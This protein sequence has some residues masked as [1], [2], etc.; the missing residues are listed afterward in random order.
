VVAAIVGGDQSLQKIDRTLAVG[1]RAWRRP[2][3][4]SEGPWGT[5]DDD[6]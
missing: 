3:R 5:D 6:E 1:A 2:L 4:P